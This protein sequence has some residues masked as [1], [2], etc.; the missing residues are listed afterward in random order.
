[1]RSLCFFCALVSCF[2][3][4]AEAQ[5]GTVLR[6]FIPQGATGIGLGMAFDGASLY[7]TLE[8]DANIYKVSTTGVF[9]AT[10]SVPGGVVRGAPLAWDGSAL[11]ALDHSAASFTLYR[12]NPTNGAILTS[13]NIATQN[14]SHPAV[15]SYPLNIG[16]DPDGLDWT[17]HSLWINGDTFSGNWNAE[18]DTNCTIL[19]AYNPPQGIGNDA[20]IL[21][22]TQGVA[23][24]GT[25][26]WHGSPT[27]G[28]TQ[29][30][31]FQTDLNGALTGRRFVAN[32]L[33]EDMAF[34]NVTFAPKCALWGN[35]PTLSQNH[36]TAYEIPCPA[37]ET[38]VTGMICDVQPDGVINKDDLK[39]M[40]VA[41]GQHVPLG[42]V[43]DA[44]KD[45]AVTIRDVRI[46]AQQ[47]A[48]DHCAY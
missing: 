25:W 40:M 35:E 28:R 45:G 21:D 42:D 43:R 18:V 10:I 4:V 14:P 41:L 5:L 27:N 7:Y 48:K 26:L 22:G 19:R 12:I 32:R 31:V 33:K 1:M 3:A 2:S 38:P 44:D 17:G 47:C 8:A 9:Q 24:D 39:L 36:L 46:C 29:S 30:L 16:V 34:D 15:T 11:W 37:L 23:F 13:C 20:G 6:E